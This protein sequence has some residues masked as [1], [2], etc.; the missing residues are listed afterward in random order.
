MKIFREEWRKVTKRK[1]KKEADEIV[2]PNEEIVRGNA[3]RHMKRSYKRATN[4]HKRPMTAAPP[5][6]HTA[7][8]HVRRLGRVWVRL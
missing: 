2:R 1:I 4:S 5:K 3:S 6:A 7:G 8:S